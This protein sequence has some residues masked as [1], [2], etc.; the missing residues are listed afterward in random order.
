MIYADV[1]RLIKINP[2]FFTKMAV[3]KTVLN[4]AKALYAAISIS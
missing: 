2:G 4:F 3:A 1:V